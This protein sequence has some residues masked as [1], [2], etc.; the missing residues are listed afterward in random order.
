ML[1]F[2]KNRESETLDDG[3]KSPRKKLK[4]TK[5]AINILL[6]QFFSITKKYWRKNAHE[7]MCGCNRRLG[8]SRRVGFT[9]HNASVGAACDGKPGRFTGLLQSIRQRIRQNLQEIT[10]VA[11]T[12]TYHSHKLGSACPCARRCSNRVKS[13]YRPRHERMC[14]KAR[15]EPRS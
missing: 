2:P 3:L 7:K 9:A 13:R 5:R 12:V 1:G 11:H 4:Y 6:M 8:C 15:Y 10:C 14:R